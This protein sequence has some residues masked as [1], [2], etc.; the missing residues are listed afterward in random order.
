MK[1]EMMLVRDVSTPKAP[2]NTKYQCHRCELPI[3]HT[4]ISTHNKYHTKEYWIFAAV[5]Q[6]IGLGNTL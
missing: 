6:V 1:I 5:N 3:I 2:F 4:Y